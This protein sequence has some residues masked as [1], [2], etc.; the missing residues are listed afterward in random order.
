MRIKAVPP[1]AEAAR[2]TMNE[3]KLG[4]SAVARLSRKN[5]A[6]EAKDTYVQCQHMC[7]RHTGPSWLSEPWGTGPIKELDD[8]HLQLV[9]RTPGSLVPKQEGTVP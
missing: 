2:K 3:A 5:M 6:D 7:T 9:F 4:A 8:G 1:K